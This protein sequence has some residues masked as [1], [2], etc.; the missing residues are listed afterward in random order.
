MKNQQ[1]SASTLC[2]LQTLVA[3]IKKHNIID[4]YFK[5][6]IKKQACVGLRH[7]QS[8]IEKHIVY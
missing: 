2:I 4:F 6:K 3:K 1:S 8:I 7:Q 5:T